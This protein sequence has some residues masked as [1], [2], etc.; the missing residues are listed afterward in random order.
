MKDRLLKIFMAAVRAVD[1]YAAV[2]RHL[3]TDGGTLLSQVGLV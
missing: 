2:L 1:P 3:S